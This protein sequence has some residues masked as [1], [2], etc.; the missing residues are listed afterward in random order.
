MYNDA[1]SEAVVVVLIGIRCTI[2]VNLQMTTQ[3]SLNPCDLGNGPIKSIPIELHGRLGTGSECR[4]PMGLC[5]LVLDM[6][7]RTSIA[8]LV[9][10]RP[11]LGPPIPAADVVGHLLGTKVSQNCMGLIDDYSHKVVVFVYYPWY[12]KDFL[13][14]SE[15]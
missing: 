1:S 13:S 11:Y 4:R 14:R 3:K 15:E 9:G 2:E 6:T 7:R 12:A 5:V 10:F 8:V